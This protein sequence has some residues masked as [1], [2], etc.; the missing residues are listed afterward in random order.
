MPVVK[1]SLGHN[2]KLESGTAREKSLFL[3]NIV[4]KRSKP[5]KVAENTILDPAI[6]GQKA[7]IN[8][9]THTLKFS[10]GVL[11]RVG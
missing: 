8:I 7:C 3:Q 9:Y 6:L 2:G 5:L 10:N 11:V 1:T 4:Y